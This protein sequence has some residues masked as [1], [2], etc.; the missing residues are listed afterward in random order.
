MLTRFPLLFSLF[1]ILPLL[2]A[3][4]IS[5]PKTQCVFTVNQTN[6]TFVFQSCAY[7]SYYSDDWRVCFSNCCPGLNLADYSTPSLNALVIC[8]SKYSESSSLSILLIGLIT[9]AVVACLILVACIFIACVRM[10][11]TAFRNRVFNQD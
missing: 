2:N 10:F 3:N 4:S 8:Q 7:L 1:I 5:I 11:K 9:T 6:S